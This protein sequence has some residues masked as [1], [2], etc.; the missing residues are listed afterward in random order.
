MTVHEHESKDNFFAILEI[1]TSQQA[2][3]HLNLNILEQY[4]LN[5]C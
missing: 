3:N 2:M 4:R 5:P 1:Y